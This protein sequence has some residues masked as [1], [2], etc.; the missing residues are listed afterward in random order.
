MIKT[1]MAP[2]PAA[3]ARRTRD[4]R[5]ASVSDIHFGHPNT[6]TALIASNLKGE[7]PHGAKTGELD[8]ILFGGD[9]FD[10]ALSYSDTEEIGQIE[11]VFHH[12]L[13]LGQ[14]QDVVI[15][16]LEGTPS[17]DRHQSKHFV[18]IFEQFG[19]KVDFKYIQEISVEYIEKLG[20]WMLYVPDFTS[21]DA[22][23]IWQRVQE[24]MAEAGRETVDYANIHGAFTYQMPEVVHGSCHDMTRYLSIVENYIFTG[25]IHLPSVW[26]RIL[27]N[28]SFDRLNHGEEEDKGHWRALIRKSGE[29][30]FTF[31]VN[32]GA[33]RYRSVSVA[34]LSMEE[35]HAKCDAEAAKLPD[36]SALR[37]V[38]ER[39][40]PLFTSLKALS[41][42][43]PKLQWTTKVTENRD[44]QKHLLT[45]HRADF[46]EVPITPTNIAELLMER[47][48]RATDNPSLIAR[49]E[50]KIGEYR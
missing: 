46:K 13:H 49:C 3:I 36:N 12:F 18:K 8:L 35:A 33:K 10:E 32:H 15:R 41:G 16:V 19:Y 17:H 29:D 2:L 40:H 26:E 28:G 37:V 44:V 39:G 4:L 11:R 34:G 47:I 14:E 27:S 42:S 23:K 43:Y 1:V 45:D 50:A 7:F 22:N 6:P 38:G 31:T 24:V 5:I 30:D 21:P 9:L 20:I 48:R 25:H